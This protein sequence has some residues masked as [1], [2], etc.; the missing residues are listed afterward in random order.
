MNEPDNSEFFSTPHGLTVPEGKV[1]LSKLSFCDKFKHIP[2]ENGV[3]AVRWRH[4][5]IQ[6][7]CA[8]FM[9][10][11]VTTERGRPKEK[12]IPTKAVPKF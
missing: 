2:F 11:N 9:Y 7:H 6:K 8:K 12:Y 10:E 1:G 5:K 3:S 4:G